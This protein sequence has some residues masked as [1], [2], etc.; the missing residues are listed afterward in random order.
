MWPSNPLFYASVPS[1][2]DAS[3]APVGCENLFLLIPIAAGLEGDTAETS[4]K[5]LSQISGMEAMSIWKRG[6][7]YISHP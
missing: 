6:I 3:V 5:R 7:T 2:T 4:W 1:V